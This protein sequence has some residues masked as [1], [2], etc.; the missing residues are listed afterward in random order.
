MV[1]RKSYSRSSATPDPVD[2][3]YASLDT[4]DKIDT[5]ANAVQL[6]GELQAGDLPADQAAMSFQGRV[7]ADINKRILEKYNLEEYTLDPSTQEFLNFG[8]QE[9]REAI[10]EVIDANPGV[11]P[12]TLNTQIAEA[13]AAKRKAFADSEAGKAALDALKAGIKR[14]SP[15]AKKVYESKRDMYVHRSEAVLKKTTSSTAQ[16]WWDYVSKSPNTCDKGAINEYIRSVRL[17]SWP[18]GSNIS[19]ETR[20]V[21]LSETIEHIV[22]IPSIYD[23]VGGNLDLISDKFD[24]ILNEL[25]E[26]NIIVFDEVDTVVLCKTNRKVAVVFTNFLQGYTEEMAASEAQPEP[27]QPPPEPPQAG[28]N[29]KTVGRL[30]YEK[31]LEMFYRM[32]NLEN[33]NKE[34]IF[35]LTDRSSSTIK[36]GLSINKITLETANPLNPIHLLPTHVLY[37][38]ALKNSVSGILICGDRPMYN[39]T[40]LTKNTFTDIYRST[41][42]GKG[43]FNM[44]AG[45][46][47]PFA[48]VNK[49][50]LCYRA[51]NKDSGYFQEY[52][53]IFDDPTV[54]AEEPLKLGNG[55]KSYY[56]DLYTALGDDFLE[57][58]NRTILYKLFSETKY[59]HLGA[60]LEKFT[61][62]LGGHNFYV[63]RSKFIVRYEMYNYLYDNAVK[64]AGDIATIYS[65][66]ADQLDKFD[67]IRA[68]LEYISYRIALDRSIIIVDFPEEE[69]RVISGLLDG[70]ET[71]VNNFKSNPQENTKEKMRA[72]MQHAIL[73][74]YVYMAY[75]DLI[76][77]STYLYQ[78][79]YNSGIDGIQELYWWDVN[80]DHYTA[81]VADRN[82]HLGIRA[83][84]LRFRKEPTVEQAAAAAGVVPEAAKSI[85]VARAEGEA[86]AAAADRK[87]KPVEISDIMFGSEV[88]RD[89]TRAATYDR[90]QLPQPPKLAAEFFEPPDPAPTVANITA[91]IKRPIENFIKDRRIKYLRYPLT[92][93]FVYRRSIIYTTKGTLRGGAKKKKA[94]KAKK[95]KKGKKTKKTKSTKQLG[96]GGTDCDVF[97]ADKQD[98]EPPVN[99]ARKATLGK[100][101][102]EQYAPTNITV[103]TINPDE[104]MDSLCIDASNPFSESDGSKFK[105]WGKRSEVLDRL[106]TQIIKVGDKSFYT[107]RRWSEGAEANWSGLA[108]TASDRLVKN[109]TPIL[110]V[111]E[112]KLL[113]DLKLTPLNMSQIF[114]S[115]NS[116]G[117]NLTKW[118][119]AIPVFFKGLAQ[120]CYDTRILLTMTQCEEVKNFLYSI[121]EYLEKHPVEAEREFMIDQVDPDVFGGD[122]IQTDSDVKANTLMGAP[123][124]EKNPE[125]KPFVRVIAIHKRTHKKTLLTVQLST[126]QDLG[127]EVSDE[128]KLALNTKVKE[129]QDKYTNYVIY[130]Y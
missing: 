89:A 11:D 97:D 38:Y 67:I 37:P 34:N 84:R 43:Q 111:G 25:A 113:N 88:V 129:L 62:L 40:D 15:E 10:N 28:G 51:V 30:H 27:P 65:T 105:A 107:I 74:A 121:R 56:S 64:F 76:V 122:T 60:A 83:A 35:F 44:V 54:V 100:Y 59:Y 91:I 12:T 41:N 39:I 110:I 93:E 23:L 16:K 19:E 21:C 117:T 7:T 92:S 55:P 72:F 13:I 108:L 109:I 57:N 29:P 114:N 128:N 103:F 126:K 116:R 70:L 2:A 102:L 123:K 63:G 90:I 94:K 36:F 120:K 53:R 42:Y 104:N 73:I 68:Y 99:P 32:I 31:L 5:I 58:F 106:N 119:S 14:M 26:L 112:A 66:P 20:V 33:E 24:E 81:Y 98:V 18:K 61:A 96:G 80:H 3:L 4:K 9:D 47:Y 78:Y 125:D 22:H 95:A 49:N 50:L 45:L 127:E 52:K 17:D 86:V 87:L 71:A 69:R 75:D 130:S 8:S 6:A 1:S 77:M 48:A 118:N 79:V 85:V 46:N 124:Y 115:N 101:D 82:T